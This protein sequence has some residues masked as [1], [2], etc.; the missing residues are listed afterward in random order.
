MRTSNDANSGPALGALLR[1]EYTLLLSMLSMVLFAN[2]GNVWLSS[3]YDPLW[4][5]GMLGWLLTV[6][7][8]SAFAIVR[9][10]ESLAELL[11][12]PFGTLVLTLSII[13]VEV[14]M[15]SAVMLSGDGNPMMARD[16]MF[17]VVM[18]L[19]GGIAGLSLLVG[20]LKHHEQ[21]YNLEGARTFLALIIPLAVLG[22]ILP[23]FTTSTSAG[24]LSAF[25]SIFLSAMS[26]GIYGIFLGVQTS[27]HSDYF[28]APSEP[29]RREDDLIHGHHETHSTT[30]H[31]VFLL[32]YILP[33][34]LLAK[35]LATPL[36][37]GTDVL[38]APDILNGFVVALLIL[39]P[40]AMSAVK[41]ALKNQL[42]RAVNILLGSVLATIGLTIPAVLMIGLVTES[43]I[44]LGLSP[45][46]T[47]VL[48]L[49]LSVSTLTFSNSRTNAMLGAVHILMFAAY[50]MLMFEA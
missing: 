33:I 16:T 24:T 18:I 14:L 31:A 50:L 22:L 26:L 27:R 45:V 32:L 15:I 5:A 7:L 23:N 39:A 4:F 1:R 37:Y 46:N 3:L 35:K 43:T 47:I 12:E 36:E 13:G 44:V 19:L 20:G 6:I 42:Q 28:T 40:E 41:A 21:S 34:V 49:L 38:G 8:M 17:S 9:H 2:Y 11:G 29:H 48:V 25:Q 30:Y 10:A